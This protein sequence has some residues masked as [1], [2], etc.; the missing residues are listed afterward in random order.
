M[1]EIAEVCIALLIPIW[2]GYGLLSYILD[3]RRLILPLKIAYSYGLG[4][5]ILSQWML[6][7][8]I[9]NMPYYLEN[10]GFPLYISKPCIICE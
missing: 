10:I 5:G 6:I 9:L 1:L 3:Q 4:V 2:A 8:G 7:L